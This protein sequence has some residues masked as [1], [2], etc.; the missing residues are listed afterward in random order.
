[1]LVFLRIFREIIC[2][3]K[4]SVFRLFVAQRIHHAVRLHDLLNYGFHVSLQ[5]NRE[6]L[7][8]WHWFQRLE[9]CVKRCAPQS[10]AMTTKSL[11]SISDA[12]IRAAAEHARE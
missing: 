12:P 1:M 4:P 5:P 6:N 11:Q 8:I 9:T 10:R 7:E 2:D 3:S